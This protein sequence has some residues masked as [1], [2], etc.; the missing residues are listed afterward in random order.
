MRSTLSTDTSFLVR[1]SRREPFRLGDDTWVPLWYPFSSYQFLVDASDDVKLKWTGTEPVD[2]IEFY[3]ADLEGR[4]IDHL[5]S[6]SYLQATGLRHLTLETDV[7]G[8][9]PQWRI[10]PAQPQDRLFFTQRHDGRGRLGFQY[11]EFANFDAA[12]RSTAGAAIGLG[13]AHPRARLAGRE[14]D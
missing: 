12:A 1:T 3:A 14:L 13:K 6:A 8:F 7:P 11:Q 2:F 5:A 9:Q 10:D 4:V